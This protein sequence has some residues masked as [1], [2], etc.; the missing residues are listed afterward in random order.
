MIMIETTL[1]I[2]KNKRRSKRRGESLSNAVGATIRTT[3][4]HL[5]E[6]WR[7]APQPVRPHACA[8]LGYLRTPLLAGGGSVIKIGSVLPF[9]APSGVLL[10]VEGRKMSNESA[11]QGGVRSESQSALIDEA[12]SRFETAWRT[13]Q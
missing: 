12:C 3:T 5:E 1:P 7:H 6:T 10:A 9:E 8:S 4:Q 2:A 13:G 11:D